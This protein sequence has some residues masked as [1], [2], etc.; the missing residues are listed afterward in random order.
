[1]NNHPSKFGKKSSQT[2]LIASPDP[3]AK[4][5]A[6]NCSD[7]CGLR[8]ST[9]QSWTLRLTQH[10]PSES[11]Q[12][13]I[14]YLD[15]VKARFADAPQVYNQFLN[16]MKDFKSG[17]IDTP[18][19]IERVATLF[20]GNP[21]LINR[22]NTF[23][24]PGYKIEGGTNGDPNDHNQDDSWQEMGAFKRIHLQSFLPVLNEGPNINDALTYLDQVKIR[25]SHTPRVYS[26]FLDIMKDFKTGIIDTPSVVEKVS[27]L[28]E[29]IPELI[30]GFNNF[31]PPGYKIESVTSTAKDLFHPR[32]KFDSRTMEEF[33]GFPGTHR[34]D[35][36]DEDWRVNLRTL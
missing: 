1:M 14:T 10:L 19:V 3:R 17:N 36:E 4:D 13:P 7:K 31:L 28:F 24:P 26:E 35:T 2:L 12:H 20:A 15:Q 30:G 34:W 18:G 33:L 29:G 23:L 27:T 6:D 9:V 32:P 11:E 25:F 22:F 16:V 5:K 21:D 8:Y